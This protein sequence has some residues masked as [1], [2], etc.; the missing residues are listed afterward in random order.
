[1]SRVRQGVSEYRLH[2]LWQMLEIAGFIQ[3]NSEAVASQRY[4]EY[5]SLDQEERHIQLPV[6]ILVTCHGAV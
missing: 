1:M 6:L 3:Q 4:M 2:S 5:H